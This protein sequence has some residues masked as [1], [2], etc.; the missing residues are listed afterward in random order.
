MPCPSS[1]KAASILFLH[2]PR[3]MQL[4]DTTSTL[5][6]RQFPTNISHLT[7]TFPPG[8]YL[9]CCQYVIDTNEVTLCGS[10][11]LSPRRVNQKLLM[12]PTQHRYRS[13]SGEERR[14]EQIS[15]LGILGLI[16]VWL[17]Q[18]SADWQAIQLS[19]SEKETED[20]HYINHQFFPRIPSSIICVHHLMGFVCSETNFTVNITIMSPGFTPAQSRND[21]KDK[22]KKG[23]TERDERKSKKN[24]RF[25]F[26]CQCSLL[27][28]SGSKY[29]KVRRYSWDSNTPYDTGLFRYAEVLITKGSWWSLRY[30]MH[31]FLLH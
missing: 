2:L 13:L 30:Y 9:C 29:C 25:Y 11:L 27:R 18:Q 10:H 17:S 31:T 6:R 20:H 3:P 23:K 28:H 14:K 24:K 26:H 8:C 1:D 16:C 21:K 19:G 12:D 5:K 22:K 4:D 15:L 7:Q